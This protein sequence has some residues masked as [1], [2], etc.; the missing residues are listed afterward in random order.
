[1]GTHIRNR[2][3]TLNPGVYCGGLMI[4]GNSRVR[5]NP[6][7]YIVQNGL[8]K[9]GNRATLIGENV[10][11][12]LTGTDTLMFFDR[13]STIDLTAPKSG[14]L[15][16]I[17]FFEDSSAPPLRIHRIASNNARN[18]L[19]TIYLPVGIPSSTPMPPWPT[20]PTTRQSS[21]AACGS[22]RAPTSSSTATTKTPS[23]P[24]PKA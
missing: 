15:A 22:A 16:G 23:S 5:L 19:G 3:R 21:C 24:S 13:G 17:L 18:L 10:G 1:V 11:F 8:F 6:G 12:Y 14:P 20:A 2:D 9:V 4:M 7:V